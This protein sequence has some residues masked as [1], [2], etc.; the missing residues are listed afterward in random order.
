MD[1]LSPYRIRLLDQ[2]LPQLLALHSALM[3]VGPRGVGKTTTAVRHAATVVRLDDPRQAGAFRVDPDAA[4]DGLPEP[5]L[6]D[7]WQAVSGLLGAVKRAVDTAP[8]RGRFLLAGS[9]TAEVDPATWPGVGRVVRIPMHPLTVA[10]RLGRRTA[11]FLERV[12]AA[13]PLP[14]AP[15]APDLRELI[16]I[17]V[18]GGFPEPLFGAGSAGAPQW[19]RSYADHIA[20]RGA[21]GVVRR[22]D[23]GRLRNFLDACA[24]GS[25]R[26]MSVE[27]LHESAAVNRRTGVDYWRH[28]E[29]LGVV[30]EIPAWASNRLKRL[31]RRPKRS[32]ADCGLWAS[33][34]DVGPEAVIANGD[35]LGP[36]LEI[37]VAS[38]LRAETETPDGRYTLHHLREAQ[39]RREVDFVAE[40]P[41]GRVVGI[42]VKATAAPE[43]RDARHLA[44]LR[45]ELGDRFVGGVVLHAGQASYSL[46]ERV[47]AAP[48]STL[49]A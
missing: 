6:L 20:I 37:L 18:A 16:R 3:I 25:M 22:F 5:V 30:W 12:A 32:V 13:E 49:W 26:G 14:A 9:A 40:G 4:L 33:L 47:R 39:G 46:G 48:I 7:E 19:Y 17:A 44:W 15:E 28:L 45:D 11:P 38:Q 2:S 29:R 10:E 41:R 24:L 1:A 21:P 36:A 35:L 42:E 43:R 27:T 8:R 23:A 34:L 31:V